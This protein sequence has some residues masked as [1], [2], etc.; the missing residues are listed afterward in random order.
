MDVPFACRSQLEAEVPRNTQH[1]TPISLTISENV[2][3]NESHV[4]ATRVLM[5]LVRCNK[6]SSHSDKVFN[7]RRSSLL[8]DEDKSHQ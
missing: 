5:P 6:I 1:S 7:P 4:L 8:T 3:P 2:V